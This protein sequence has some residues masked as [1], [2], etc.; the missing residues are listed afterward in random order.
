MALVI[1]KNYLEDDFRNIWTNAQSEN[2]I[3]KISD[4]ILITEPF[5]CFALP[6][7]VDFSQYGPAKNGDTDSG[8]T[9][10][11]CVPKRERNFLHLLR[12]ELECLKF[13]EKKN[14]LYNFR[15][16]S[17]IFYA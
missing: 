9:S 7:F 17:K 2:G 3:G 10:S 11:S 15:Q 8:S 12:E 4:A 1:N 13:H 6:N 5:R 16:V 14:D